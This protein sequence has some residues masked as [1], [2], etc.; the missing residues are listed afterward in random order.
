MRKVIEA[1]LLYRA[2]AAID[3]W[4]SN[5]WQ[6]SRIRS[7]LSSQCIKDILKSSLLVRALSVVFAWFS[8]K[9]SESRIL[10]WYL[11][12]GIGEKISENS[13]F[14]KIWRGFHRG[15]CRLFEKIRLNKLLKNSIFTIPFMWA[16]MTVALAP[17][18]PTLLGLGLVLANILALLLAFACDKN[19]KLTYSPVNK[20]IL[21]FALVYIFA[22]FTSVTFLG[23]IFSGAL[24]TVFILFA[25]VL[26]NSV[27]SK[28]Q[29]DIL[30]S[31]FVISGA[32]VSAYGIYQY[33]FG[34]FNPAAWLDADMFGA[35]GVRVTSTLD[36]PNVLAMYLLL[37]I[38]FAAAGLINAK[39]S[40]CRLF[41]TGCLLFMLACLVLTF[42]RGGWLGLIVSAAV[43]LVLIDR[44]FIVLGIIGLIVLYFTL[45]DVVLDRILSIGDMDDT[46]TNFRVSIWLGTIAMLRDFWFTGI[47]P[48][49]EAFT[50]IYPL[51]S[52]HT[53]ITPHS[54]MLYLQLIASAGFAGITM[55]LVIIFSYFRYMFTAISNQSKVNPPDREMKIMQIA[56]VSAVFGFLIQGF[57]DYSFYNY[58]VTLVFWAVVG[59]GVLTARL[60]TQES[61]SSVIA[62]SEPQ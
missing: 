40:V 48:G 59:I 25:V 44:R 3:V 11:S 62:A 37:V 42:S 58:R 30:I 36:N 54:H 32:L 5:Q 12:E 10:R 45:P 7:C 51:Y 46:S 50:S 61:L 33:F 19:R 49:I 18:L 17:L 23:S 26:I 43:F 9:W 15:L 22:T 55:F 57:T 41:F 28:N 27:K 35:I 20:Y 60:S 16:F 6:Q 31:A 21:I 34:T 39:G 13:I 38:P 24:T 1:S 47:G 29:L 8:L 4:F 2:L 56:A 52:L 53:I 14:T